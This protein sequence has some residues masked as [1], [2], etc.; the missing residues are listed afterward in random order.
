V[1]EAESSARALST[2]YTYSSGT[3]QCQLPSILS[4]V[5]SSKDSGR[6]QARPEYQTTTCDASRLGSAR[7]RRHGRGDPSS[8]F[9][10]PRPRKPNK[11]PNTYHAP[12]GAVVRHSW[13]PGDETKTRPSVLSLDRLLYCT[14]A[15]CEL[16]ACTQLPP[17]CLSVFLS[18]LCL[19]LCL[20]RSTERH[21]DTGS[22]DAPGRTD[23]QHMQ[24]GPAVRL[25]VTVAIPIVQG[26]DDTPT[27]FGIHPIRPLPLR[28]V[29]KLLGGS[30]VHRPPPT[31]IPARG[32]RFPGRA[33]QEPP[34]APSI[35]ILAVAAALGL[36]SPSQRPAAVPPGCLLPARQAPGDEATL[37]HH[38][39]HVLP[40]FPLLSSA[41]TGHWAALRNSLL[42]VP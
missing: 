18:V 29:I 36:G 23:T 26:N 20:N 13:I 24:C 6:L 42:D 39:F 5:F 32:R 11:W 3:C 8:R 31:P 1:R 35:P 17:A 28:A 16:A 12:R 10:S 41:W 9:L 40:S 21:S 27:T 34:H 30:T 14:W 4:R 19:C 25:F 22:T 33:E 38:P 37:L 7:P 15:A 2:T